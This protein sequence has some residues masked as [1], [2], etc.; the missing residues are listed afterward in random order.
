MKTELIRHLENDNMSFLE[1]E[2]NNQYKTK[3]RAK[4]IEQS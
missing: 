4:Q 1:P 3:L 2:N